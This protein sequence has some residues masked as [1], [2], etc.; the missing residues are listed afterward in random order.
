[1][2]KFVLG[3]G[4]L[5]T[6]FIS[7]CDK[8]DEVIADP[9]DIFPYPPIVVDSLETPQLPSL[10]VPVETLQPNTTYPS[11]FE[12][13]TRVGS[14]TTQ[15]QLNIQV[16]A[17]NLQS[18][19]GIV[20]MP[21]GRL[22]ITSKSGSMYIYTTTGALEKTIT[23]FENVANSGQGGMLDVAVDPAF[24]SNKTIYWTFA[25]RVSGGTNTA[26][27]KGKLSDDETRI[28]NVEV[29]F[30]ATP[31]YNG[32]L[33]FGSRIVFDNQ[34]YIYMS[35]GE[36]SDAS[37]RMQAQD[38]NSGL[39][40][41]F[42]LTTSGQAAPNNPFVGQSNALPQLFSYG[43][44]NPQGLAIHPV[45][46]ELW[47]S[48][49][50]T[51]G[52]D[53]INRIESGKNYGWPII[54]YGL[55]YSGSAIGAG[56]QQQSGMEQPVYYWDP[57]IS[58]SGID[59]YTGDLIPEWKN[60]LFVGALSGQHIIRLYIH[61]NK[62]YGEE[63]LLAGRNERFRDVLASHPDGSVYAITDSGKIFKITN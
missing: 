18:P 52:G 38:K 61:N 7:S 55:E 56:I 20:N 13:Q 11:A 43:H 6:V 19:W 44:R 59:F 5:S 41:V 50:G 15:T 8:N 22:L 46:K 32:T 36:R 3:L 27:A 40:K 57:S 37:M 23:G 10:G 34:G 12:G 14:I 45:T 29:V 54:T 21:D 25:E 2:K 4:F 9:L 47:Q 58:P 30:R 49:M 48:E 33:H 42:K 1:M 31:S 17:S 53:E 62:I 28:E 51:R 60:N 63:R 39:G 24:S 26:L 16:I 35:T